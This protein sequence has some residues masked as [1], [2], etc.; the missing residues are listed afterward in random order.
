MFAFVTRNA[1]FVNLFGV[2]G[3]IKSAHAAAVLAIPA[4]MRIAGSAHL[5][6]LKREASS[7]MTVPAFSGT[8]AVRAFSIGFRHFRPPPL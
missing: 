2:S 5:P 4:A 8:F 1:S 6:F 7:P 3:S